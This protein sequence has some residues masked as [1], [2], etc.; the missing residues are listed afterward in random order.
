VLRLTSLTGLKGPTLTFLTPG[1]VTHTG[2][3]FSVYENSSHVTQLLMGAHLTR[4]G[5]IVS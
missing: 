2:L 1:I 3:T 4:T 5:P